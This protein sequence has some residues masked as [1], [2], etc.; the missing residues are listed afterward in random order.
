MSLGY[1]V[2]FQCSNFEYSKFGVLSFYVVLKFDFASLKSNFL[3][4]MEVLNMYT[5]FDAL[6]D[7]NMYV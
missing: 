3:A 7:Q 5:S 2:N 6:K 4:T 1:G